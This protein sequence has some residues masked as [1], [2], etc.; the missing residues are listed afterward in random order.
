MLD[1]RSTYHLK[2]RSQKESAKIIERKV[3]LAC[4]L[5]LDQF[6]SQAE[7][8]KKLKAIKLILS[9]ARTGSD[10]SKAMLTETEESITKL[11]E[12]LLSHY[13]I[14]EDYPSALRNKGWVSN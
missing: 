13:N 2:L 14:V 1:H 8:L 11:E 7:K 10:A 12:D 3:K 5:G 4:M 9:D 6:A